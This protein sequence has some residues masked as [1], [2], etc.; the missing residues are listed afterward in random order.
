MFFTN[1][2]IHIHIKVSGQI[3]II[4]KPECFGHFAG[5]LLQSPP[6]GVTSTEVAII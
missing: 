4:P 6:F 3:M 1:I 2:Y 5:I